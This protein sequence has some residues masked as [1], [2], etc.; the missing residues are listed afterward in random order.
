M[1]EIRNSADAFASQLAKFML[2]WRWFVLIAAVRNNRRIC[3][4]RKQPRV[5]QQTTGF[6]FQMKIPN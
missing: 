5:F 3:L 1:G 4:W 6:S 2:Q